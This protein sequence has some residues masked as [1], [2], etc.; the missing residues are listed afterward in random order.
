MDDYQS[1][2]HSRVNQLKHISLDIE[3]EL[4]YQRQ[5]LTEMDGQ[6]DDSQGLLAASMAKVK[7]LI[8]TQTGSWM[9]IMLLFIVCVMSYLYFRF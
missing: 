7:H 3:T 9:W 8:R 4:T 6:F 5:L 1:D 2:L